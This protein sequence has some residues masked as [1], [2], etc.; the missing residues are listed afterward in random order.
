MERGTGREE[1]KRREEKSRREENRGQRLIK[2]F[3]RDGY[4]VDVMKSHPYDSISTYP[5]SVPPC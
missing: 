1:K 3:R 2:R 5:V 4:E